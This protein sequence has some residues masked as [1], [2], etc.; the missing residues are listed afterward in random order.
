MVFEWTASRLGS[1]SRRKVNAGKVIVAIGGGSQRKDSH[2][3]V[4]VVI[5]GESP[6]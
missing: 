3:K 6:W 4:I 1:E 5:E 2:I